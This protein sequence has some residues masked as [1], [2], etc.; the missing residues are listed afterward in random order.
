MPFNRRTIPMASE[1]KTKVE[2]SAKNIFEI[3][4]SLS[5]TPPPRSIPTVDR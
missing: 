4:Y 1:M 2:S 3:F 5:V